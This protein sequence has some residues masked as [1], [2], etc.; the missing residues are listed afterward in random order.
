[1]AN[2]GYDIEASV[3]P[4][5]QDDA[6]SSARMVGG[7]VAMILA[8]PALAVWLFF[9]GFSVI[10]VLLLVPFLGALLF[11]G[12]LIAGDALCEWRKQLFRERRASLK[13]QFR[14]IPI[15]AQTMPVLNKLQTTGAHNDAP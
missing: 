1:M 7:L 10:Q 15:S 12:L 6:A 13:N 4:S 9:K 11:V 8:Y 3:D 14:G 5:E 2:R